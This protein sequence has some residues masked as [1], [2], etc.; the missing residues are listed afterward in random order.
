MLKKSLATILMVTMFASS[1][2][3]AMEIDRS[4]LFVPSSLGSLKVLH[5]ENGFS[6][7]KD[8]EVTHVHNGFIDKEIR[9]ITSEQLNG[10]LGNVRTVM[11]GGEPVVLTRIMNPS[12][13]MRLKSI[14]ERSR[15]EF[16]D[17]ESD[18]IRSQL[19]GISNYLSV[20]QT[21][22]GEYIIHA[23]QRL[24]GGG[25]LSAVVGYWTVKIGGYAAAAVAAIIM[26]PGNIAV[27]PTVP[28]LAAATMAAVESAAT[29]AGAALLATPILP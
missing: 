13:I 11:I 25:P 14:P 4:N 15:T 12:K 9:N 6:I 18:D 21:D 27:I 17:E 20:K 29:A 19:N 10:F 7:L 16:S 23:K 8:G 22:D 2:V 5:D 3:S 1:N 28:T 24:T 26:G